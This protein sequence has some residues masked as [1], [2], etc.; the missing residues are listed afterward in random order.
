MVRLDDQSDLTFT[1]VAFPGAC[2]R[3]PVHSLGCLSG[4]KSLALL[5]Q[6]LAVLL[7]VE[8]PAALALADGRLAAD[9]AVHG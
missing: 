9:V 7:A 2:G 8:L 4:S 5:A 6:N 3:R 1:V